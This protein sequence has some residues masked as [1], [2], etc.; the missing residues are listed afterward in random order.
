MVKKAGFVQR[1][2]VGSLPLMCSGMDHTVVTLQTHHCVYCREL[3]CLSVAESGIQA[4][5]ILRETKYN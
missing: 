5:F 3:Q 4:W 1:P 2:T